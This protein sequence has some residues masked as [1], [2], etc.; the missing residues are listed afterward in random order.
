MLEPPSG[1]STTAH[2]AAETSETAAKTAKSTAT[3][4]APHHK[5]EEKIGEH[6]SA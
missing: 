6:G 2:A 5:H 1:A 4:T 3:S